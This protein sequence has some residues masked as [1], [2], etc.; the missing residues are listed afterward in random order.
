MRSSL[1]VRPA[2]IEMFADI[3][4]VLTEFGPG[5]GEADWRRLFDYDFDGGDRKN[6]GWVLCDGKA[7]VGFLGA[8]FSQRAGESFCNVTSWVVKKTFRSSGGLQLL[9]PMFGLKDH[10]ILNLSPT[11]FTRAVFQRMGFR[12]LEKRLVLIPPIYPQWPARGYRLVEDHKT[13]EKLLIGDDLRVFQ[14]H[15]RYPCTHLVFAGSHDYSYVVAGKTRL[16]RFPTSFVYYR[17]DASLFRR[18]A[19]AM[20]LALLRAHRTLFSIVDE[21]LTA[22]APLRG[23]PTYKLH[24]PRLYRPAITSSRRREDIDT[25]YSEFVLLDPQ[26]W[27]FNY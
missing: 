2:T 25:L 10:T 3:R 18:L 12:D 17:S 27:T 19:G 15:R 20:Q 11:A 24:Q 9:M 6:R 4:D 23:C 21:R 14:D 26:R 22:D 13:I 5:F 7:I 16:R 8:I 1:Q